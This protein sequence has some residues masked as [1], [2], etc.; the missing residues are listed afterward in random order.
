MK[1]GYIVKQRAWRGR[2][3]VNPWSKWSSKKVRGSRHEF[4]D[5]AVAHASKADGH[6]TLQRAVFFHGEKVAGPFGRPAKTPPPPRGS[7]MPIRDGAN[8][9]SPHPQPGRDPDDPLR[10][11]HED[12]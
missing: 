4:L 8:P 3:S 9:K 1:A 11:T 12:G 6:R 10:R 7:R 5:D 2:G